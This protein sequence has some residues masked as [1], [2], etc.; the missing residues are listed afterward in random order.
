MTLRKCEVPAWKPSLGGSTEYPLKP[1]TG[2]WLE[3]VTPLLMSIR[4]LLN[5]LF[6]Y[7]YKPQK[8]AIKHTEKLQAPPPPASPRVS[9]L[10]N[11]RT[12]FTLGKWTVLS[13]CVYSGLTDDTL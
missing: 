12:E 8:V 4:R 13:H 7:H 11:Y 1:G 5:F 9:A 10:H 2:H 6:Q 3:N